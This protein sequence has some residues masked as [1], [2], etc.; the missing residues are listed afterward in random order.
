MAK[1]NF[2]LQQSLDGYVDHMQLGPPGPSLSRHFI[3]HVRELA[4]CVYGRRTY[5]IMRDWD[6]DRPDWG[7]EE[8]AFAAGL[9]SACSKYGLRVS[10][11]P[12]RPL[13]LPVPLG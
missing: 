4:G 13:A 2:G 1:L 3:E 9:R 5:E 11:W 10:A 6:E 12:F 7:A 8:F